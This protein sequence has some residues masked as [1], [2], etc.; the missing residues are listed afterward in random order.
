LDTVYKLENTPFKADAEWQKALVLIEKGD[1]GK[2][3]NL[4]EKII[5]DNGYYAIFANEELEKL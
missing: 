4:L 3:R 1:T 2:A 5:L